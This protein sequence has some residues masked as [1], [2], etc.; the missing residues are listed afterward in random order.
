MAG[1]SAGSGWRISERKPRFQGARSLKTRQHVRPELSE[2]QV[3]SKLEPVAVF[4]RRALEPVMSEA[5][6]VYAVC[7]VVRTDSFP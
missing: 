3:A 2:L 1:P 6:A 7:H 4:R 5:A